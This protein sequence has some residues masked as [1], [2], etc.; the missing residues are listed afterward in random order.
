MGQSS[1]AQ[2]SR[3]LDNNPGQY[4]RDQAHQH[5][6]LRGKAFEQSKKCHSRGDHKGAKSFSQQG[7]L[8]DEKMKEWNAKASD[9]I[10]EANNQSRPRDEI[11][12]HGL[13]VEEAKE[14]VISRIDECKR[15]NVK[16]LRVIVGKGLHSS[17]GIQKLK[18][19]ILELVQEHHLRCTID[20]HNEG[21]L[22]V[23]FV[24]A[25]EEGI[26]GRL[27]ERVFRTLRALIG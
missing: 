14:R 20:P 19:A 12:L 22:I 27:L 5:A 23:E 9:R 2:T 25:G 11:D 10:F 15:K 3:S 13:Y 21:C 8:E 17:N 7:H 26:F 1:S 4:E 16:E 24:A 18:P 6:Q